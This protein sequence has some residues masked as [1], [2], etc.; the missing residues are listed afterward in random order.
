MSFRGFSGLRLTILVLVL[1]PSLVL[2]KRL[3][4]AKVEP[5]V[6]EGIRYVAPNDNGRRAYIQAWDVKTGKKLWELT[7]FTNRI[8]PTLEEDV[9]WVFIKKLTVKEA[10]LV[11]TAENGTAHRVDLKKRALIK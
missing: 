5:A 9:Q 6:S 1:L 4:P 3:A 8:D 11:V 2:A 10:V 7:V